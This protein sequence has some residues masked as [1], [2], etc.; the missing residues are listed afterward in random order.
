VK[1]ALAALVLLV[2]VVASASLP[3]RAYLDFQVI[4]HANLGLL[5]GIP[6]YDHVGQ[7]EMIAELAGVPVSRVFVLP[8]PYPPWY[9]LG[10]VWLALLPIDVAARVWFG[11]SL[12]MLA[13]SVA[14]LTS[15]HSA[16]KR[17]LLSIAGLLWLPVLGS[18]FVGQYG[19]PV[20]LGAALITHAL[21]RENVVLTALAA[22]LLT[23]KPHLGGLLLLLAL[24]SLAM[25]R[26]RFG[27]NAL[28]AVIVSGAVLFGLGF[29]ASPRWPVDY[30]Q[31]LARFGGFGDVSQCQQCVSLATALARLAGGGLG[32]AAWISAVIA[33][34]LGVWLVRHWRQLTSTA[35]GLVVPGILLTLLAG[36]Y[37]LNYDYLLLVVP[38]IALAKDARRADWIGLAL[39]FALPLVSLALLGTRGNASLILST[40]LVAL[41]FARRL[42][43]SDALDASQPPS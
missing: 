40:C 34:V 16:A 22:A 15:D 23:F 8:F 37:L 21:R 1:V 5:R 2:I 13:V 3:V 19:F 33:I 36:P 18:L 32:Q 17:G 27:R 26:D 30:F 43:E 11:L 39:A 4:F 38:F 9:A 35:D 20:L 6:V 31:S 42:A 41:L 25:R 7:V 10:T 29:L 24:S 12:M 28:P 14:V